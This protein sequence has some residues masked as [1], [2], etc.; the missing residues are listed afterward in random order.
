[1]LPLNMLLSV[2]TSTA[3]LIGLTT[4]HGSHALIKLA[5]G[6]VATSIKPAY[7]RP[8]RISLSLL[9]L[10]KRHRKSILKVHHAFPKGSVLTVAH[11]S[12]F[13]APTTAS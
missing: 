7:A 6:E 8:K 12:A 3:A 2:A 1:M 11:V 10:K 5:R 4:A 9:G 13:A